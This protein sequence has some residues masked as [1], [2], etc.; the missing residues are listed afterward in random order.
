M[1]R[2]DVIPY[3]SAVKNKWIKNKNVVIIDVLRMGSVMLT[4]LANGA[5]GFIPAASVDK[6]INISKNMD[7]G[8]CLLGGERD[9]KVIKGF[10]LGNSPF[11]YTK[12]TVEDKTIILTTTNGTVAI[13]ASADAKKV[14]IGTFLNMKA[15]TEVLSDLEEVV[16]VCSGTNEQFSMDDGMCAAMIIDNLD[17]NHSLNLS[18]LAQTLLQAYKSKSGNLK[19]LLKDCYHL[20]LLKRNGFEKD[21][22]YCLQTNIYDFV[23]EIKN[24]IVV[25]PK[26][27][28]KTSL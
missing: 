7:A 20:N 5:K 6:A 14:F 13:E 26:I 4:G 19:L 12:E 27:T 23:P 21:V 17:R 11:D 25:K 16:L 18:D 10:T 28:Q 9:T 15:L 24:T 22:T 1:M 3:A 2:I 8:T